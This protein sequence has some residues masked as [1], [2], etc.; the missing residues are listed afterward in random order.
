[1][2]D[3]GEQGV[4]ELLGGR[5]PLVGAQQATRFH[6]CGTVGSGQQH[7]SASRSDV[8]RDKSRILSQ[9]VHFIADALPALGR[10]C[11]QCD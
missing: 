8:Y 9:R 4:D 1:V 3:C 5:V 11:G 10:D 2:D 6:T 7:S